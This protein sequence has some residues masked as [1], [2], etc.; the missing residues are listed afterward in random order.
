LLNAGWSS[1]LISSTMKL[2]HQSRNSA[3]FEGW[4]L[5]KRSL[6]LLINNQICKRQCKDLKSNDARLNITNQTNLVIQTQ[7]NKTS[8]TLN[9]YIHNKK[10]N[11]F[12]DCMKTERIWWTKDKESKQWMMRKNRI[13]NWKSVLSNQN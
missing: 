12:K 6:K 8:S 2:A 11:L 7:M 4:V 13:S 10:N 5:L 3:V 1:N 9:S